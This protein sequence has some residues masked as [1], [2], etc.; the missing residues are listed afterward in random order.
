[1][2]LRLLLG[3]GDGAL[4]QLLPTFLRPEQVVLAGVRMLDSSEERFVSQQR[5]RRLSA[6]Q[7]NEDPKLIVQTLR[8]A[9]AQQVYL[10]VNF[11][12]LDPE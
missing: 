1:M 7:L 10:H 8:S 9:G 3:D 5:L 2:P 12:V 11:D 6:A 4:K